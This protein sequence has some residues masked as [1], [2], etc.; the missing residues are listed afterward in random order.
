MRDKSDPVFCGYA[1]TPFF[2]ASQRAFIAAAIF[3]L[4]SGDIT[5]FFDTGFAA[6]LGG[7]AFAGAATSDDLAGVV[8][9]DVGL[10]LIFDQRAC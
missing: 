9:L 10:P 6:D 2:L 1:A 3:A 8:F 4:A 7:V 5:F